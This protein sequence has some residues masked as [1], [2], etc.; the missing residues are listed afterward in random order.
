MKRAPFNW[1]QPIAAACRTRPGVWHKVGTYRTRYVAMTT[2]NHIRAARID[3]YAP[4]GTFEA[5][6][7]R[8]PDGEP[9]VWARYLKDAP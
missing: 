2:A 1:H 5:T 3:A 6:F 7:R 8:D 4:A 9:A